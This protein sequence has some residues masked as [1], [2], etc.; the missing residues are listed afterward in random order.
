MGLKDRRPLSDTPISG[1]LRSSCDNRYGAVLS[2]LYGFWKSREPLGDA[3]T[4]GV[5]GAL[6]LPRTDAYTIISF[7]STAVV[8]SNCWCSIFQYNS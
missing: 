6:H 4:G 2:A 8:S 3:S 7:N 5:R 1:Q